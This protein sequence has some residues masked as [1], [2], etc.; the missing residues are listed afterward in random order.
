VNYRDPPRQTSGGGLL[1]ASCR[2]WP[3]VSIGVVVACRGNGS[4]PGE[5]C[6]SAT[7]T[8]W[9]KRDPAFAGGMWA[10]AGCGH[11]AGSGY[12]R[13]VP[14][15]ELLHRS[16]ERPPIHGGPLDSGNGRPLLRRAL[17]CEGA[18]FRVFVADIS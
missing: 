9:S 18:E 17:D 12:L 5:P 14:T 2:L 3:V 13:E 6:N 15:T 8:A 7:T 4:R 10:S 1:P 16:E 11:S